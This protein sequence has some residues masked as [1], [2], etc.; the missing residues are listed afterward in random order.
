MEWLFFIRL[1]QKKLRVDDYIHLKDAVANEGNATNHG[2]LVI[3]PSTYTKG[4]R[5]MHEYAQDAITYVRHRDKP[6][7]F[8]IY[9]FNPNCK[10]MQQNFINGQSTMDRHDLVA[11]IFQ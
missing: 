3:L 9:I 2:K 11:G 6:S 7:L 8:I 5:N 4:P 1:N 10:Q